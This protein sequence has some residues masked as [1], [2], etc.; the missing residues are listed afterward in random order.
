MLS[1]K[2]LFLHFW[3]PCSFSCCFSENIQNLTLFPALFSKVCCK[4]IQ[5]LDF[6]IFY[7]KFLKKKSSAQQWAFSKISSFWA[8]SAQQMRKKC[9]QK[10]PNHDTLPINSAHFGHFFH[11][12]H[13]YINYIIVF[14]MPLFC[15]FE[16]LG[17]P[18][19]DT[20]HC[21]IPVTLWKKDSSVFI[22]ST[23]TVG[24][25]FEVKIF[26]VFR[27]WDQNSIC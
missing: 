6:L 10:Y 7:Q 8:T 18:I 9:V 16:D 15:I 1:C 21:W 4:R 12:D 20:C 2:N 26:W 5:F 23:K 11:N 3:N 14:R 17:N 25:T 19:F 13:G 24:Y 27:W 22:F